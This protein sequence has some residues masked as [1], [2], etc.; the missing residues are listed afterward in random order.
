MPRVI[1]IPQHPFLPSGPST[2]SP[3][4][5][6]PL[7][8]QPVVEFPLIFLQAEI[9]LSAHETPVPRAQEKPTDPG[10]G[11]EQ[12]SEQLEQQCANFPLPSTY[13]FHSLSTP[14]HCFKMG[15]MN[16]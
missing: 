16:K 13:F 11:L 6:S 5:L 9:E 7:E 12:P 1:P 14:L 3:T 4:L 15:F 8:V 10:A 2:H